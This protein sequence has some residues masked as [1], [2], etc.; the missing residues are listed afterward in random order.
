MT[1]WPY[2]V[3]R[4]VGRHT[5]ATTRASRTTTPPT[6]AA[7]AAVDLGGLAVVHHGCAPLTSN[8]GAHMCRRALHSAPVVVGLIVCGLAAL[9]AVIVNRVSILNAFILR[10]VFAFV[11]HRPAPQFRPPSRGHI[12]VRDGMARVSPPEPPPTRAVTEYSV[13]SHVGGAPSE[14]VRTERTSDKHASCAEAKPALEV[15]VDEYTPIPEGL[16]SIKR[17][18][19]CDHPVCHTD[20]L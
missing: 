16:V 10:D 11:D 19:L 9:G 17:L 1:L 15:A 18:P 12:P 14:K 7:G 6:R 20:P 8:H 13:R 4:G 3:V 2:F 5:V